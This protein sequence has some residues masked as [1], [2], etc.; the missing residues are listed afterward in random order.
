MALPL[1][2]PTTYD[3]IHQSIIDNSTKPVQSIC[4][5]AILWAWPEAH[6]PASAKTL[7]SPMAFLAGIPFR[8]SGASSTRIPRPHFRLPRQAPLD[9]EEA[10]EMLG[11]ASKVEH[12]L[13]GG[14]VGMAGLVV[15]AIIAML[16]LRIRR[17]TKDRKRAKEDL[18]KD[19][20]S[21][22]MRIQEDE[23]APSRKPTIK[24][25]PE[26]PVAEEPQIPAPTQK[27]ATPPVSTRPETP[28]RLSLCTSSCSSSSNKVLEP[29]A[30]PKPE[31]VPLLQRS[32][33]PPFE[34]PYA[35]S[36]PSSLSTP[37]PPQPTLRP[38]PEP[39]AF[40]LFPPTPPS[41]ELTPPLKELTAPSEVPTPPPR[42]PTPPPK[43]PTPPPEEPAAAPTPEPAPVQRSVSLPPEQPQP[44]SSASSPASSARSEPT[45]PGSRKPSLIKRIKSAF[46]DKVDE[47]EEDNKAAELDREPTPPPRVA[48]RPLPL[49]APTAPVPT[50]AEE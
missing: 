7:R 34:P 44:A 2:S 36:S 26:A 39:E 5:Q 3:Q 15:L 35:L 41:R 49:R 31:S 48:T 42:E 28:R 9:P 27:S 17:R 19:L 40:V 33:T 30:K 10:T 12:G 20:S 32:V 43:E 47:A 21:L 6:S 46:R 23:P 11:Q 1:S 50:R 4:K 22:V 38:E 14:L 8:G 37:S 24:S 29:A 16:V 13:I 45:E 18:E 25:D